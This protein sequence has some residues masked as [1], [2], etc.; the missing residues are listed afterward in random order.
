MS[1]AGRFLS[2]LT[3]I[4]GG[5][6]L[7]LFV[8][9]Y[10]GS[11]GTW[12]SGFPIKRPWNVV[13]LIALFAAVPNCAL[14]IIVNCKYDRLRGRFALIASLLSVLGLVTANMAVA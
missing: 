9:W 4:V 5:M 3:A 8:A 13:G 1:R 7:A 6:S 11:G 2:S 12:W 10:W 14:A